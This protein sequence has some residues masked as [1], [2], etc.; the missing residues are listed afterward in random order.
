V[1]GPRQCVVAGTADAIGR[2]ERALGER[3]VT[4]HA[5]RTSHA[6]HSALMEPMLEAFARELAGVTFHDPAIPCVSNVT[7][8]LAPAGLMTDPQYWL[9]H[10]RQPVLFANGVQTLLARGARVFVEI[11]PGRGLTGLARQCGAES[12]GATIVNSMPEPGADVSEAFWLTR[13]VARLWL[14]G[15]TIDWAGL[16]P[17]E[18]RR[19]VPLPTYAFDR[20]RYWNELPTTTKVDTPAGKTADV[21]QWFYAPVWKR[22]SSAPQNEGRPAA[23][24]CTLVCGDTSGVGQQIAAALRD[25]GTPVM[26]VQAGTS[27]DGAASPVEPADGSLTIDPSADADYD[28][29]VAWISSSDLRP[30]H[31]VHCWSLDTPAADSDCRAGFFGPADA[32]RRAQQAGLFSAMRV[33]QALD[34]VKSTERLTFDIVSNGLFDVSG[35][36]PL[37]PEN[38]PL[39]A[40][41]T[42]IPQERPGVSCRVFDVGMQQEGG[43][44]DARAVEA[45][46]RELANEADDR[47]LSFR[48]G[49]RWAQHF[50]AVDP[51]RWLDQ[52]PRLRKGGVYLIAGGL[53][54]IGLTLARYLTETWQAR[55]VLTGR[56]PFPPKEEWAAYGEREDADAAVKDRV[57]ALRAMEQAGGEVCV[58]QA[59]A[60]RVDEMRAVRTAME[61]KYGRI[62]GIVLGAGRMMLQRS[63]CT[64]AWIAECE[65]H[66]ESKVYGIMAAR[67]VFRDL[68]L[69]FC[70][71][72]SSLSTVLGGLGYLP[73]AGANQV[74]D[75]LVEQSNRDSAHLWTSVNWDAWQF[76]DPAIDPA[77]KAALLRLS[78][79]PQEGTTAFE[80]LLKLP[81]AERLVISTANLQK[82]LDDWVRLQSVRKNP[83]GEPRAAGQVYGRP[84]LETPFAEPE[85]DL[86][87][88]IAEIWQRTLGID[89]VG[90]NDDFFELGGHSLVA[91]QMLSHL[92]QKFGIDFPIERAFEATTVRKAAIVL[93]DLLKEKVLGLT[94]EEAERLLKEGELGA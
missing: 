67:E 57:R 40:F 22:L 2:L 60:A 19:R 7:G 29:L 33:L 81:P 12:R 89:R 5:L 43:A 47:V 18:T 68:P 50:E 28:R 11:G 16:Y 85:G 74:A 88:R 49:Y 91:I 13:A 9:Q 87:R 78:M 26:L 92:H 70:I 14:A 62:D 59:N 63:V 82:R 83:G 58:L 30:N 38:G 93:D 42:V 66:F 15:A 75:L 84:A 51:G 41:A 37:R 39:L 35:G 21:T 6:F 90:R 94:E 17:G 80:M 55:V 20:Q 73:Y 23:G 34:E 48:R 1:N 71:I 53:G 61:E 46:I 8:A 72:L 79:D 3:G 32:F 56:S 36:E 27:A 86:E 4:A 24:R 69:D 54:R 25:A 64:E 77:M 65:A 44:G 31:V 45:L 76:D 52:S 10:V